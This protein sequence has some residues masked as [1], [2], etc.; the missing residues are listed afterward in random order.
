MSHIAHAVSEKLT[1][2]YLYNCCVCVQGV[3][4]IKP[5]F[6]L[7]ALHRHVMYS[8]KTITKSFPQRPCSNKNFNIKQSILYI[9]GLREY[10]YDQLYRLYAH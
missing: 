10:L 3:F 1:V 7:F 6:G 9:R 2:L 8:L 4:I 5:T